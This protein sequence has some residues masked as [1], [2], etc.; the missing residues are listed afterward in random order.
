MLLTLGA[1]H[2][3]IRS[4]GDAAAHRWGDRDLRPQW[5]VYGRSIIFERK[6]AIG[7]MLSRAELHSGRLGLPE[8]VDLCNKGATISQGRAAF[9]AQDDFAFVSNRSGSPA[10]WRADLGK[11]L[12]NR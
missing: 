11:T 7:A 1:H 2:V 4:Q 9:F 5:N 3:G 6:S 12:S 10:I 8:P